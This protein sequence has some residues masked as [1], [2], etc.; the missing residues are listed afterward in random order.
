MPYWRMSGVYFAYFAIIGA[1]YPY[2]GLYLA[3]LGYEPSKIGLITAIPFFTRMI[4]PNLW[5]WL[6]DHS[7]RSLFIIKLGAF[8]GF[9]GFIGVVLQTELFGLIVFLFIFSFFWNAI[10]AQYEVITLNYLADNAHLYSRIRLWGSVG[11]IWAVITLGF[12]FK[13]ISI[14]WLGSFITFLLAAI[15]LLS[16]SLPPVNLVAHHPMHKGFFSHLI[17]PSVALVFFVFFLLHFSHGAYYTFYSIYLKDIGYSTVSIGI[18]WSI[19]VIA[20]II[21]F[22]FMPRILLNYTLYFLLSVSLLLTSLRWFVMGWFPEFAWLV[23]I[24]QLLHA[25]S[26]GMTHAVAIE[27]IR[28]YFSPKAQS[29]GQAF[30]SAIGFG[31]GGALGAYLSGEIWAISQNWTFGIASISA[32]VAWLIT[33]MFLKQKLAKKMS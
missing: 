25:A 14:L 11:F 26:F 16:C 33:I 19:G 1:M 12:V 21:L 27:Y 28:R 8:G 22:I 29:H 13:F 30:Y 5:G 32:I 10:L 20:E 2:W 7:G 4:A 18:M 3:E 24:N 23:L 31:A 17:E 15:W 9:L 6:A